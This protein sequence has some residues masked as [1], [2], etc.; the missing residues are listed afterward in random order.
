MNMLQVNRPLPAYPH[1]FFRCSLAVLQES[2]AALC[3]FDMTARISF[4]SSVVR[5]Q[6]LPADTPKVHPVYS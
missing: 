6:A 5:E 3:V 1:L 2:Y 4:P